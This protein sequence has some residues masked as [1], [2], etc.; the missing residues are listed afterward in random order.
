MTNV[1]TSKDEDTDTHTWGEHV[2][3]QEKM[4]YTS[5]GER[6]REKPNCRP[7]TPGT[8]SLQEK[9]N[10]CSLS[11]PVSGYFVLAALGN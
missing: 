3:T 2:R 9:T 5:P 10:F 11:H 8:S 7:E 4:A 6:P 1:F